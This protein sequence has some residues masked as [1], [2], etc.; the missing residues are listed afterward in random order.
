MLPEKKTPSEEKALFEQVV[1]SPKR[2]TLGGALSCLQKSGGAL[3]KP[4]HFLA[5]GRF[6]HC[7]CNARPAALDLRGRSDL[8]SLEGFLH[9]AT[10]LMVM[11]VLCFALPMITFPGWPAQASTLASL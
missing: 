7:A 8:L 11:G 4:L 9:N 1:P 5:L 2:K 10:V 3:R 6:F